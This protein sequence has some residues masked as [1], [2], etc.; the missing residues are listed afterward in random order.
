MKNA[1]VIVGFDGKIVAVGEECE[2]VKEA[3]YT[4]DTFEHDLNMTG[5]SIV[6][7]LVDGHTHPVRGLYRNSERMV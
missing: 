6:P 7:G 2:L 4:Q 1:S 5:K 3:W